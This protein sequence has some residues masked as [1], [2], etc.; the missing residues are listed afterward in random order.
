[1]C[2]IQVEINRKLK[3]SLLLEQKELPAFFLD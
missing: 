2:S 3:F 1:V